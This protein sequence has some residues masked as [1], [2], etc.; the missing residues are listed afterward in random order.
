MIYMDMNWRIVIVIS[1]LIDTRELFTFLSILQPIIR[2]LITKKKKRWT[3]K[4]RIVAAILVRY[5][6]DFPEISEIVTH[7]F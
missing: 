4:V 7:C 2:F 6:D 5:V 1:M 3:K